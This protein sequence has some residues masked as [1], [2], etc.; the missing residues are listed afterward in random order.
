MAAI[1]YALLAAGSWGLADFLAGM[2]SRR[3]GV[4]TVLLWVEG[5]GLVAVMTVIAASGE[6]LPGGRAIVA[7]IIAG[8]AGFSALGAFYKAL[9]IG[10]MSIVAPISATGVVL[11]VVVGLASG[12]S[13]TAIVA[14][15]LVVTV[16]GV[17]AASREEVA[18]VHEHGSNRPAILLAL[19][20]AVG[21]GLYF[22]FADI[23]ADGSVLWL[24]ALGRIVILPGVVVLL[25]IRRGSVVPPLH[26]RWQL[27]AIGLCDLSATALYGI[28]T[29]HG[30][31]S[32]VAV[33]GSLYPVVT[34]LLAW[35]TLN[36]R[37]SRL[38]LAGVVAALA[39]VAMVSTG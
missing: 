12:D 14:I 16:A 2:K 38:Q 22:V 17:L 10:T 1:A 27:A 7:S 36:E 29:T 23:G 5:A 9:S 35:G 28:A 33:I 34:V 11:P 30:A 21:F 8:L 20:A 24:L 18:E 37:I 13:L 25:R 15:G 19:A 6:P 32:I 39:G 3:L 26:D 31:L 4:L